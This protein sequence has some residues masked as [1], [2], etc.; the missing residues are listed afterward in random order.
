MNSTG[1]VLGQNDHLNHLVT[2]SSNPALAELDAHDTLDRLQLMN[3]EDMLVAK[4]I[5]LELPNIAKAIHHIVHSLRSGGRLIYIGAGTS[6]RLGVL[7]AAECPPTFGTDPSLVI[8]IIAGGPEA[9]FR[10]VEGEEDNSQAGIEAVSNAFVDKLDTVVGISASGQAPFVIEALRHAASLGA[11]TVALVNNRPCRLSNVVD[12]TI[13]PIVG[14]EVIAGS[15]R[16]KAGTAQKMVLNLLSTNAMI[17]FGKTYG[18]LMV[19]VRATNSKL[20]ARALRIT[21]EVTGVTESVALKALEECHGSAKL[22]ILVLE[23]GLDLPAAT[24]L[25]YQNHGFL[26]RALQHHD[27]AIVID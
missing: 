7:D 18:N 20:R 24:D 27:R 1:F 6:G 16:M 9:M 25:L 21:R 26:R 10:A 11:Y 22:A 17:E 8:G 4:A 3:S 13:A 5:H 2:E 12:T 15:T 19:D 14:P 23:T